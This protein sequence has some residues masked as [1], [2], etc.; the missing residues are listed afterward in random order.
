MILPGEPPAGGSPQPEEPPEVVQLMDPELFA[1]MPDNFGEYAKAHPEILP[2]YL[3]FAGDVLDLVDSTRPDQ[4]IALTGPQGIGKTRLL[5]P[6]ILRRAQERGYKPLGSIQQIDD[7]V[8]RSV[9][10]DAHEWLTDKGDQSHP[11]SEHML[12]V[13]QDL[14]DVSETAAQE[15]DKIRAIIHRKFTSS[16]GPKL[17]IIDEFSES[18][19][20]FSFIS[21]LAR[22]NNVRL[23]AVGP[24]ISHGRAPSDEER[25]NVRDQRY[26]HLHEATNMSLTSLTIPE[27]LVSMDAISELLKVFGIDEEVSDAFSKNPHLRRL[28]MVEAIVKYVFAARKYKEPGD[29]TIIPGEYL[30]VYGGMFY[31]AFEMDNLGLTEE[32]FKTAKNDLFKKPKLDTS[33]S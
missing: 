33:P 2:D 5:V 32:E 19:L 24:L 1:N 4:V 16:H 22:K 27:Q 6:A 25:E 15:W 11:P 28:A 20:L 31:N 8:G 14:D 12:F 30:R 26:Q 23:V 29:D 21:E 13:D 18:F 10:I 9:L 17:F 7:F 3:P